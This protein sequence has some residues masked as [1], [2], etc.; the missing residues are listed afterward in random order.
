MVNASELHHLRSLPKLMKIEPGEQPISI[1]LF[2]CRPD[3]MAEAAEKAVA[4]GGDTIDINMGCPVNK[5]TKK[6]GGSSL[7]FQ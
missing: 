7:L 3:F 6:G 1:Q 4:E 5:I 2:D